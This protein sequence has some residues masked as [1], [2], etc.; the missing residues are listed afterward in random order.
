MFQFIKKFFQCIFIWHVPAEDTRDADAIILHAAGTNRP[1]GSPGP[2]NDYLADIVCQ[3][4]ALGQRFPIVPQGEVISS[5]AGKINK[6]YLYGDIPLQRDSLKGY[7]DT[8]DILRMQK[9]VCAEHGWKRPILVTTRPHMLRALLVARNMGIDAI[10]YEIPQTVWDPANEQIWMRNPWLNLPR[11]LL[12][13]V[14]WLFQGKL[15]KFSLLR[16]LFEPFVKIVRLL[17]SLPDPR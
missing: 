11:E 3:I 6:S 13:R 9:S 1:D 15:D 7:L 14:V 8:E 17:C 4:H 12:V 10:P 2:I 5:L 16:F